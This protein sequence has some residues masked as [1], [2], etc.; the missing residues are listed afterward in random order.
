ME[1]P[2]L[3]AALAARFVR[4]HGSKSRD[5]IAVYCKRAGNLGDEASIRTWSHIAE[6]V[7]FYLQ[8]EGNAEDFMSK[9]NSVVGGRQRF[10]GSQ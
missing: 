8:C 5:A 4:Q 10:S 9:G 6:A 7:E 2:R 1:E 3:L